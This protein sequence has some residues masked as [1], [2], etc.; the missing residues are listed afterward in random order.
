[1]ESNAINR[2]S[3]LRAVAEFITG[4]IIPL[5]VS[6]VGKMLASGQDCKSLTSAGSCCYRGA[7]GSKCLVGWMIPDDVWGFFSEEERASRNGSGADLDTYRA[8][9]KQAIPELRDTS[10]SFDGIAASCLSGAQ[11]MIHDGSIEG[12]LI[13]ST[14]DW[15]SDVS[16]RLSAAVRYYQDI[17]KRFSDRA[18]AVDRLQ[19]AEER[20]ALLKRDAALGA[21]SVLSEALKGRRPNFQ[22][23]EAKKIS[24]C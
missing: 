11:A 1:M 6:N 10:A 16:A 18:V 2:P 4:T 14:G 7:K 3:H 12:T 20:V 8:W 5:V 15:H 19:A 24:V 9:M 21:E 23:F 22:P 17:A 13:E